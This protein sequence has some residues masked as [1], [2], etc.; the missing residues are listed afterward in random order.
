MDGDRLRG[1]DAVFGH[2]QDEAMSF[3]D[4]FTQIMIEGG[5]RH[6]TASEV[7][8]GFFHCPGPHPSLRW[9]AQVIEPELHLAGLSFTGV[10]FTVPRVEI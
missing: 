3:F 7:G 1:P 9:R 4:T 5:F 8:H 6:L 2:P 10:R